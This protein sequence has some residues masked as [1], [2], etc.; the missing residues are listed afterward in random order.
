MKK[1]MTLI[2]ALALALSM[3]VTAFAEDTTIDQNTADKTGIATVSY[4]VA[5]TYT[6]TI[7]T[8]VNLVREKAADGTVTYEQDA[9]I[10][11]E[12]V[13]LNQGDVIQVTLA[14][15]EGAFK[16]SSGQT[17]W[18]YAVTV[19]DSA[20]PISS[21]DVV[22]TFKTDKNVTQSAALHFAADDPAYAGNYSGTVTFTLSVTE[23]SA[24]EGRS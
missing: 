1:L 2:L 21:G 22:A 4:N 3:S 12:N 19:D 11:A 14:G 17:E 8:K 23:A 16:M 20:I 5:P 13:R 18:K 7:P 9:E 6:V 10:K 24:Q 15:N